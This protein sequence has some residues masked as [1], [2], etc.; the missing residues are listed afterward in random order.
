MKSRA[1]ERAEK[2][3]LHR[4]PAGA[5]LSVFTTQ[6]KTEQGPMCQLCLNLPLTSLHPRGRN[7]QR[8]KRQAPSMGWVLAV[9]AAGPPGQQQTH[10]HPHF[11]E[12]LYGRRP[13]FLPVGSGAWGEG[14]GLPQSPGN[15]GDDLLNSDSRFSLGKLRPTAGPGKH[16]QA[17]LT[18][19]HAAFQQ[20]ALNDC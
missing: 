15:P 16:L 5:R 18:L 6:I 8:G 12:T 13:R 17:V 11:P 10:G 1:P 7:C 3:V 9:R 20:L 19:H 14:H 4:N 2:G